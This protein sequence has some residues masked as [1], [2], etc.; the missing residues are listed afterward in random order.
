MMSGDHRVLIC[1]WAGIMAFLVLM[2]PGCGKKAMPVPP[3]R[4]T[5]A[6]VTNF[7]G[8]L[9][10]GQVQ[11]SWRLPEPAGEKAGVTRSISS[12]GVMVYRS[13]LPLEAGGCKGCPLRFEPIATLT[14]PS[15][16]KGAMR[17]DDKLERGFRYTYK[18]VLVGENDA[19]S[20]DSDL[21]DITY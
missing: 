20:P 17:Y 7:K 19:V 1:F 12:V 9:A 10:E 21:L 8:Q 11:L 6:A 5:P 14:P 15:G 13:K 2:A 4:I 16:G 18:I 3:N